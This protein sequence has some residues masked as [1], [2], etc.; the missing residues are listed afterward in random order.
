[1]NAPVTTLRPASACAR[2]AICGRERQY[3]VGGICLDFAPRPDPAAWHR[4]LL[5]RTIIADMKM[6]AALSEQLALRYDGDPDL[7][8]AFWELGELER[9]ESFGKAAS[10]H[11]SGLVEKFAGRLETLRDD[12][13]GAELRAMI[14]ARGWA[15]FSEDADNY[16]DQ[17]SAHFE[18]VAQAIEARP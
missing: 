12:A 4:Q 11:T 13:I 1:M 17:V 16:F 18:T 2:C 3:H 6:L 7:D 5:A 10:Y 8:T 14:E 9:R 15:Q